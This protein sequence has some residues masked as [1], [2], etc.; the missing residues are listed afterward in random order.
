M[1]TFP[2]ALFKEGSKIAIGRGTVFW[3]APPPRLPMVIRQPAKKSCHTTATMTAFP[4]KRQYFYRAQ[5]DPLSWQEKRR[6]DLDIG[7]L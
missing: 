4:V 2:S 6:F 1:K 7:S 5:L 3:G